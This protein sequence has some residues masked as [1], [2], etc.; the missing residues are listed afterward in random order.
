MRRSK[1]PKI[2]PY[3]KGY[4]KA[5]RFQIGADDESSDKRL[6]K[7]L[8]ENKKDLSQ[9]AKEIL[10]EWNFPKQIEEANLSLADQKDLL[11]SGN[12]ECCC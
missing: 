2:H 3:Y 10:A 1:Y 9:H 5:L 12:F 8:S 7:F 11:R 4:K 6:K